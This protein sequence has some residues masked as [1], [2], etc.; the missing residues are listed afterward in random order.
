MHSTGSLHLRIV[1]G[2]EWHARN[3]FHLC[4]SHSAIQRY[5]N[6]ITHRRKA[7]IR[8]VGV[9]IQAVQDETPSQVDEVSAL[10]TS[11]DNKIEA[12]QTSDFIPS[13]AAGVL[14]SES[15][16]SDDVTSEL[17]T[18]PEI[19]APTTN[20]RTVEVKDE[21]EDVVPQVD[22][23][24]STPQKI[25]FFVQDNPLLGSAAIAASAF[26]GIT[27]V[28]AVFRTISKSVTASGRRSRTVNKNKLVVDEL[29]KFLPSNRS[30]LKAST[31]V[32]LKMRTGF[33]SVEIFRKYLWYLLRERKFDNDAVA[34][35]IAL[36]NIL[37]LTEK[38]TAEALTERAIRV[39][40]KYGSVMLDTSGMTSAGIE[41]K[42]TARSLFS[43]LL[44]LAESEE[45][46]P[47]GDVEV[48]LR[49]IFGATEEDV[50]RLRIASLYEIDLDA[51]LM[52]PSA[53]GDSDGELYEDK[54]GRDNAVES[55]DN[56]ANDSK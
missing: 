23:A 41:R 48:N 34:D 6:C 7:L 54:T 53:E 20:V 42:A 2:T 52:G 13:N 55:V 4:S 30:S 47:S 8:R 33:S 15:N 17:E 10:E 28:I 18:K 32:S 37:G 12:G 46:L 56:E 26:F 39:H 51:V 49:D 45:M 24:I 11:T 25:K 31:I 3:T 29:S 40:K 22:V 16:A 43:K 36:K 1:R 35:V 38:Q 44:Y 50:S 21:K 27:F 5:T 19:D 14:I 9:R